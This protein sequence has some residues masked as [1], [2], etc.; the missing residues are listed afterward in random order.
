[1][2]DTLNDV[3]AVIWKNGTGNDSSLHVDIN[4]YGSYHSLSNLTI[5]INN[6]IHNMLSYNRS[7]DLSTG[8]HTTAYSSPDGTY[9]S[10]TYCSYPDQVCVYHI[11]AP[12]P[13]SNVSI[14][15]DQLVEQTSLWNATCG[16]AFARLTGL[17]QVGSPLGMKYDSMARSSLPGHCDSSTRVLHINSSSSKSLTL[18]IAAGTNFDAGKGNPANHFSFQGAD[19]EEHVKESS[20]QL[21][22]SLNRSSERPTWQTTVAYPRHLP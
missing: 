2:V 21:L 3:R 20:Q 17:T 13:L 16:T 18:V 8:I 7:L 19:P 22:K 10:S 14:W 11:S 6:S 5:Q 15:F 1:M 9:T 12:R 4:G